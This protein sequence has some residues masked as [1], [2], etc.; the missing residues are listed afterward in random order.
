MP[1]KGE[2]RKSI[3]SHQRIRPGCPQESGAHERMHRTIKRE[4]IKPARAMC[5]AQQRNFD[6]F[7]HEYNNERPHE[8]LA[9]DAPASRYCAS[10][11]PIEDLP[12]GRYA[13]CALPPPRTLLLPMIPAVHEWR[14]FRVGPRL[15]TLT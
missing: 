5:T 10:T 11:R 6:G 1:K 4:A 7:R 14:R 2:F 3:D 12:L 8:S 15:S 9:E 13:A